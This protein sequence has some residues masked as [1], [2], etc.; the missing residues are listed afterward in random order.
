MYHFCFSFSPAKYLDRS[1]K[2]KDKVGRGGGPWPSSWSQA[3]MTRG[4]QAQSSDAILGRLDIRGTGNYPYTFPKQQTFHLE[5]LFGC[6]QENGGRWIN[7]FRGL[8]SK[9][10]RT[11]L[12]SERLIMGTW[13]DHNRCHD[14]LMWPGDAIID[15]QTD[16]CIWTIGLYKNKSTKILN[17]NPD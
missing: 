2:C 10:S 5:D 8:T 1:L 4:I 14:H 13:G 16:L 3:V 9:V 17:I 6:F 12:R 11:L 7:Y 15:H